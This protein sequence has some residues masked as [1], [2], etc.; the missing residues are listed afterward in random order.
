MKGL[1]KLAAVLIVV[2]VIAVAGVLFYVDSIAKKAIEY[3]GSEALGVSTTLADISI[4]L[5]GGEANLKQLQ[6]ANPPGFKADKFLG[7]GTGEFA[8]SLGSL[9]DETIVIPKIRLADIEVNLEQS[10]KSSNLDPILA[11]AK[12][13]SAG[14]AGAAPPSK[15]SSAGEKKFIVSRFVIEGVKVNAKLAMLGEAAN[16]KLKLPRIEMKNLGADQGGMP[17]DELIQTVVTTILEVAK[18][19]SADFSPALAGF[20]K[21]NLQGVDTIKSEVVGKATAEVQKVTSEVNKALE[22]VPGGAGG[23]VKEQTDKLLKGVE[24]LFGGKKE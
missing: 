7:L 20:L 15:S 24:G 17:M 3:G 22:Q 21:G 9:T 4:S 12:S 14:H 1:L 8:V 13:A 2:L 23:A 18:N 10:G 5:F 6:V 16:V 11:R 19:S